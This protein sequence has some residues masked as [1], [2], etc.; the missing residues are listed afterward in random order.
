MNQPSDS[1]A[2][3]LARHAAASW[4]QEALKQN[5]TLA[6]A[7]ALA[8]ERTWG[9]KTYSAS[10]LEGWYYLLRHQG[11]DGAA[12]PTAQRQGLAQGPQPGS[13][14]GAAG[15]AAKI[16]PTDH[17]GAG[18]PTDRARHA[19]G[20]HLQPALGVSVPGRPSSGRPFA[21]APSAPAA[22]RPHQGL[23][24][25]PGQPA[26]DDRHDV[27]PHPQAGRRPSHPHPPLR[28]PG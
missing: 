1:D 19:P 12:P 18:A 10:T 5:F 28:F 25:R 24:V 2:L 9:G 27:R 4:I 26:V 7:T 6:R 20:R 11:F 3:A 13:L 15:V 8:S 16:S 21:Q 17:Q 23:R 14:P 22:K